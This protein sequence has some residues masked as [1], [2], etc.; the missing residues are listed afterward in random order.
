MAAASAKEGTSLCLPPFACL[1]CFSAGGHAADAWLFPQM[2]LTSQT[3]VLKSGATAK[4]RQP[5]LN[6]KVVVLRWRWA[7]SVFR[8]GRR[9]TGLVAP[10]QWAWHHANTAAELAASIAHPESHSRPTRLREQ[11]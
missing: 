8:V 3:R 7:W 1:L 5:L 4:L 6:R 11:A 10:T 9:Q 2:L